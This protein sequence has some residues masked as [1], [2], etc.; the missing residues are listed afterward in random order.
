MSWRSPAFLPSAP[1]RPRRAPSL[2][3]PN[4]NPL[5]ALRTSRGPRTAR[6][7]AL[8]A[9]LG[10]PAVPDDIKALDE[11]ERAHRASLAAEPPRARLSDDTRALLHAKYPFLA[12]QDRRMDALM[13][14]PDYCPDDYRA[15][16]WAYRT[17]RPWAPSRLLQLLGLVATLAAARAACQAV[18][19]RFPAPALAAGLARGDALATLVLAVVAP[20]LLTACALLQPRPDYRTDGVRRMAV[21]H[22]LSSALLLPVAAVASVG[23][24][25]AAAAAGAV[26]R[27]GPMAM[28]LWYWRD[29]RTEVRVGTAP[30][31][32]VF[33]VWRA[34][35]T[36]F[37]LAG[38]AAYRLAGFV[39][40]LQFPSTQLLADAARNLRVRMGK[41]FPVA[42]SLCN[43]PRGLF[44]AACLAL[45]MGAVYGLYVA[46][47]VTDFGRI[48]N[49]RKTSSLISSL[50]LR[51]EVYCPNEHPL[52]RENR[53]TGPKGTAT[54]R[55]SPAMMLRKQDDFMT[56]DSGLTG[57][58]YVMPIFTLLDHEKEICEKEGIDTWM[59][60]RDLQIPLS[61][62]LS[63][64]KRTRDA[65]LTWARPLKEAEMDMSFAEFFD[66]L[67]DNEYQ[68][69]A[70]SGDWV[71]SEEQGSA[72]DVKKKEEIME[73]IMN[74][75]DESEVSTQDLEKVLGDLSPV[76]LERLAAS[77]E[78]SSMLR[79]QMMH[80]GPNA[81]DEPDDPSRTVFV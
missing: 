22:L 31:A 18:A 35:A 78:F 52:K 61:E 70:D 43:D 23:H 13:S 4:T 20:L 6:R 49:H 67:D 21:V 76:D 14:L 1:C 39:P 34:L 81:G 3:P 69:D 48:S 60:P 71:F 17:L 51:A 74:A 19:R 75:T 41:R 32:R 46:V 27:L 59:K 56:P 53:R 24:A 50:M 10:P 8:H 15:Y 55:P 25:A 30:L 16:S 73:H 42:F 54:F 29:L 79:R 64:S 77:P 63:Q 47:F 2:R 11:L 37:V 66:T 44:F 33:R 72:E 12:Q 40:Q 62:N 45:A 65:L 80:D 28:A 58:D 26:V 7:A 57:N 5:R 68:Y 9:R 36:V 38:G